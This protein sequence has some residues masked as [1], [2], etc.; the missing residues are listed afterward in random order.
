MNKICLIMAFAAM[1]ANAQV[2]TN[3]WGV[4]DTIIVISKTTDFGP[5]HDYIEVFNYSGQDLNMRWICHEPFT[6]PTV[7]ETDFTDTENNY[8]D[9]QHNDSADFTLLNPPGWA[10]KL[11]IGVQH[12][13]WAHTDTLRFKVWPLDFPE[14]SLWIKY[15]IIVAQGD[16]YFNLEEQNQ[17]FAFSVDDAANKLSISGDS[18]EVDVVVYNLSGQLVHQ[19]NQYFPGSAPIDLGKLETGIYLVSLRANNVQVYA[20]KIKL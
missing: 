14:D 4:E 10:N 2:T 8:N 16:D 3:T 18:H 20:Q 17:S 5:V 19:V 11:I 15:V 9:V 12:F 13:S 6:W 1:K 7:W